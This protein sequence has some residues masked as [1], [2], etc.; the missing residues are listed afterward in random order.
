MKKAG[1][2]SSSTRSRG[3]RVALLAM[4]YLVQGLPFGFQVSALPIF[5]REQGV[6]LAA[7]GYSTALAVPWALKILWA[8]LVERYG[9]RRG[10]RVRWIVPLQFGMAAGFLVASMLHIPDQLEAL[11]VVLLILN[12]LAA[13]Q[14][15]AVDGL[16]VDILPPSELGVG[17][18][19]QV[20]GYK[21]GML[22][23]GGVL[24]WASAWLG[25]SGA[26]LVMAALVTA[27]AL[28]V[29]QVQEEADEV[30]KESDPTDSIGALLGTLKRS[31]QTSGIG[32]ALAVVGTYKMGES[33]I[34]VMYKPFLIDQGISAST[35]GLWLGTWGM[36]ASVLG[37]VLGGLLAARQ[38]LFRMLLIV[39]AMRLLPELGQLGLAAGWLAV[40]DVHVIGISLA[41]HLIG[42]ALTTVMFATMMGM[43]DRRIGATHFT[44]FACVEV[45]GKSVSALLSGLIAETFSY[46]GAFSLGIFIGV[47]FLV[48]V[49]R[50]PPTLEPNR[51]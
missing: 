47:L 5:L 51:S 16:A 23:A 17:N 42:G 33:I 12:A 10:R 32:L 24:V 4:L 6:G 18:A 25:W 19:A 8:P 48:L 1:Q 45:W 26:F 20:V 46:A 7:I 43:V 3:R 37:S 39:G 27:V 13:T 14:D 28:M 44:L 40:S 21:V 50:L 41:E 29:T 38:P 11:M 34:D 49:Q 2:P 36:G 22:L 15:I 31:L 35:L 30:R 9:G